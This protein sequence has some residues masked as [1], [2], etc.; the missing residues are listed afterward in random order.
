M[1]LGL[2]GKTA[3]VTG[4]GGAICGE[5]ARGL[6]AEG[7]RVAVWDLDFHA[8]QKKVESL[9]AG[10]DRALA[11]ECDVLKRKSVEQAAERTITYFGTVD[12]LINGAGGS[13]SEATTSPDLAFFDIDTEALTGVVSLN[14]L[15]AVIPSQVVGKLFAKRKAGVILNISSC[16]G[17]R[18]LTRSI[19]YSNGKAA[20]NSFTQWLAVHMAQNYSP[21]IRVNAV[22][23]GFILTEQNRFLLQDSETGGLTE[24]GEKIVGFVPMARLGKPE[25]VVGAA[26]W[27][28]SEHAGFVTGAVISVD[29]G[30]S[31]YSGV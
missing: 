12:I 9:A 23:P 28:V 31:A 7:A 4:G 18:P 13:R 1:D 22:A 26:L 10:P 2:K 24:R 30:F 11:V 29:G 16:A 27:A 3:V 14:Y 20:T 21:S 6:S 19:G 15:S 5:I 25:E 8:A 17:F